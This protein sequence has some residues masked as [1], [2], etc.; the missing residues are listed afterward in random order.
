MEKSEQS[1]NIIGVLFALSIAFWG[2]DMIRYIQEDVPR[3]GYALTPQDIDSLLTENSEVSAVYVSGTLKTAFG[4]KL[5]PLREINTK[6]EKAENAQPRSFYALNSKDFDI[7]K[8]T[9]DVKAFYDLDKLM[10]DIGDKPYLLEEFGIRLEKAENE[11]SNLD[12]DKKLKA[13]IAVLEKAKNEL[14]NVDEEEKLAARKVVLKKAA[15][16]MRP[17][18]ERNAAI[19]V[20][21][22]V[23]LNTILTILAGLAFLIDIACIMWWYARYIYIIHPTPT[24]STH[25]IDFGVCAAFNLAA[26]AWTDPR[27]FLAATMV[28]AGLLLFRF[29]LLY[30]SPEASKTDMNILSAAMRWMTRASVASFL[31]IS[32][33]AVA[34]IILRSERQDIFE[35]GFYPVMLLALSAIG[36]C[37]T[38]KFASRIR[39]SADMHENRQRHFTPMELYWPSEL[40]NA[41][42]A[43][44]RLTDQARRGL[45]RFRN[46]FSTYGVEHDRLIS[47]VHAEADLRVQ[48]YILAIPSWTK[49][50]S[51]NA[52]PTTK[53]GTGERRSRVND[54]EIERKAFIVALSHWLDD[55]LDGREEIRVYHQIED[56]ADWALSLDLR[57]NRRM[58][59]QFYRSTVISYT[60]PA[61]YDALVGEIEKS[62]VLLENLPYL[63]FGLN[64]VAIGS[65]LF[66]PRLPY[67]ARRTM[68]RSHSS[69]LGQLVASEHQDDTSQWFKSLTKLLSDMQ[70]REDGLGHYLLGMTTKTSQEMGMAGEGRQVNFAL[71]VLYSLLYAPLLYFHDIVDEVEVGEMAAL[72][73]FDVN[74]EALIP[75]IRRVSELIADTK[76][77][78][79][80]AFVDTL[81]DSR[82]LQI[83]MAF[84]CFKMHLPQV[85][86]EELEKIYVGEVESK[87]GRGA[88][89]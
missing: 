30:A 76:N 56:W 42:E 77:G 45:D 12:E 73:T 19:R 39:K 5:Y 46:M 14:P 25:F 47:R 58:F 81:Y 35:E 36:I 49:F 24:L 7:L 44:Q 82:S 33:G 3:R 70:V 22:K 2:N 32:G 65:V 79:N 16:F 80:G 62:V 83:K 59:T 4:I 66:S 38:V 31:A 50:E 17:G 23:I 43:R 10:M 84:Q 27:V 61:F 75:W 1:I 51:G 54:A 60:D 52:N 11:E 78:Q 13:R 6:L 28:G 89:P 55:L 9:V 67:R 88:G 34:I 86:R 57:E 85:G 74:Y 53:E 37:L 21:F 41:D 40:K 8:D 29:R 64:R 26:A 87:Q 68:L 71:S 18:T 48:S 63:Y 20:D 72:E 69:M 15:I